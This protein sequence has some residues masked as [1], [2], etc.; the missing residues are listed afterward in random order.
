MRKIL[1]PFVFFI[2]LIVNCLNPISTY[3][4]YAQI[5]DFTSNDSIT[6][7]NPVGNLINVGGTLFG[8]TKYGGSNN[9]GTI[10]KILPDGTGHNIIFN[11]TG[12]AS[13]SNPNG[14]LIF[15]GTYLYG[16][17]EIGGTFNSGILFKILPDGTGFTSL[18]SFSGSTSGTY[19][20]GS[21]V[22]DAGFLYGTAS[23][24]GTTNK[25]TVFK[26]NTN[27]SGFVKL[28]DFAGTTNG[29]NP[30]G[31]LIIDSNY[32]YGTT[33]VGGIN[34][35]GTIFKVGTNGTGFTK[36]KDFDSTTTGHNPV[37]SLIIDSNFLYGTTRLGGINNNGAIFKIQTNGTAYTKLFDFDGTTNGG[38][39][40]GSLIS[41]GSFLYGLTREG[42]AN[43]NGVAFKISFD[44]SGFST[45]LNF[46]TFAKGNSPVGSLIFVDTA[47]YGI[48]QYGGIYNDGTIFKV[49]SDGTNFAKLFDFAG[50]KNGSTPRSPLTK[51]GNSIYGMTFNGGLNNNGTIFKISP[52]TRGYTKI[53]DF[54]AY[55]GAGYP[56]GAMCA[57]SIFLYGATY[58]GGTEGMGTIFK[59]RHDGTGYTTLVSFNGAANGSYPYGYLIM[60]DSFLYGMTY[61]GGISDDGTIF[62]VKKDGTGFAKLHNFAGASNGKNPIGGLVFNGTYL[63][64]MTYYGGATDNGTLFK[65]LPNGTGFSKL[66]DFGGMVDGRNPEGSLIMDSAFLYAVT[67]Y[68]GS[69]N[70]GVIFKI[71]HDGTQLNNLYNFGGLGSG[72]I[73]VGSLLDYDGNFY[74]VTSYG[75]A[76]DKGTLYKIMRDGTGFVK[77]FDF[78]GIT[79]GRNPTGSLIIDSAFLYGTTYGGGSADIGTVFK[80]KECAPSAGVDIQYACNSFKWMDSIVYTSSNDSAKWTLTNSIGCDSVVTLKLTIDNNITATD[81]QTACGSYKWMDGIV[82]TSSNNTAQWILKT[83]AGCDSVITL[84]LTIKQPT[85]AIDVQTACGSYKWMD[86]IV[87]TSSNNT[88]KWLLTNAAGCDSTIT[89]NLT[90]NTVDVGVTKNKSTITANNATATAYQWLNCDNSYAIITAENAQSFTAKVNGNYAVEIKENGCTDTSACVAITNVGIQDL[91]VNSSVFIYPNPSAN[92]ITIKNNIG[93]LNKTYL[94]FNALGQQVLSG[95]LT[96]ETT[97]VDISSLTK[98]FYFM[99]VGEENVQLFKLMKN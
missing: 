80:F 42:G 18:F 31:S 84:N 12:L 99:Q 93:Y 48:T 63:F 71:R 94:I 62:K 83:T 98:G 95:K 11:F 79:S 65:I 30:Y 28:L 61:A 4:Q 89:L 52:Q 33:S 59:T 21:L 60:V 10:F 37:G 47:L 58:G 8:L 70:R 36:L 82:Y 5:A 74:G 1:T 76:N 29:S 69:F 96:S 55:T 7:A 16:T 77:L 68:G 2:L 87:Y 64:G 25:G 9:K 66:V 72:S 54:A 15:D 86:S 43:F 3:A 53:L 23:F 67:N 24:G 27:G 20:R 17:T 90:I 19:P 44:G 35:K 40:Y 46:E 92:F 88:A 91:V 14:S 13:G 57:D 49:K 26:I 97:I 78:N 73:P 39:P 56:I 45:L 6:G 51:A 81:V 75:G 22:L 85:T 32:L 38:N 34:N 41:D 50:P